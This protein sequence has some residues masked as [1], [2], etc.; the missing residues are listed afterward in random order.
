MLDNELNS[1][2]I[3]IL[4]YAK[5]PLIFEEILANVAYS[6]GDVLTSLK[7]L[8]SIGLLRKNPISESDK[9]GF[10]YELKQEITAIDITKCS[11]YGIDLF[12]FG[13]Y[14]NIN[15]KQKKIALDLSSQVEK[16]KKISDEKHKKLIHRHKFMNQFAV[17]DIANHLILFYE[18]SNT[19]LLS[20]LE[21]L[22]ETDPV[23]KERLVLL[24]HTENELFNYLESH[25]KI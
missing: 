1:L 5:K 14:F 15:N 8:N 13:D 10:V 9:G 19:Y 24:E 11:N 22:S 6:K 7:N 12:S 21:K 3:Q 4:I 16:V 25:K 20:Y 23:L 2:I 18:A 17:D